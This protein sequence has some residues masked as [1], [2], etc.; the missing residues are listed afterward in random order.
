MSGFL[1]QAH[2]HL[3]LFGTLRSKESE[4]SDDHENHHHAELDIGIGRETSNHE[5]IVVAHLDIVV[6]RVIEFNLDILAQSQET[7]PDKS[8]IIQ[9]ISIILTIDI[10]V[11]ERLRLVVGIH[12]DNGNRVILVD[13]FQHQTQV[14]IFICLVQCA[15]SL[16]PNLHA[17][18]FLQSKIPNKK[19]RHDER[20]DSDA[21]SRYHQINLHLSYSIRPNHAAKIQKICEIQDRTGQKSVSF[22][23]EQV[24]KS[25]KSKTE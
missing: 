1:R 19:M 2:P 7:L 17:V 23:T 9:T 21:N 6:G 11:S 15:H 3:I 13:N 10:D 16:R 8:C 18:P 22:Q 4:D 5:R 12:H 25:A 20:G 14:C 24:K